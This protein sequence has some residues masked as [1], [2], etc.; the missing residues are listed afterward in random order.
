MFNRRP[1]D[2]IIE[3][4]NSKKC[5]ITTFL[6]MWH[7]MRGGYRE[8]KEDN[9]TQKSIWK[10]KTWIYIYSFQNKNVENMS[11]VDNQTTNRNNTPFAL[12]I[13]VQTFFLV[14]AW[15]KMLAT[16]FTWLKM[17]FLKNRVMKWCNWLI[18]KLITQ[19]TKEFFIVTY[20]T[21][22]PSTLVLLT[23]IVFVYD[24]K[25]ELLVKKHD[26]YVQSKILNYRHQIK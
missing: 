8:R 15:T 7:D 16:K 13:V 3:F 17:Y 19:S 2:Y 20:M 6:D 5:L 18:W 11:E 10:A 24:V 4:T 25:H 21:R 26:K 14:V 1:S 12:R 9:P 23:T 22:Q